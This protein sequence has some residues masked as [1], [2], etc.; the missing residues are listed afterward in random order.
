MAQQKF[1]KSSSRTKNN[2][3]LGLAIAA[4]FFSSLVCAA[5]PTPATTVSTPHVD[6]TQA[7]LP[8]T[9]FNPSPTLSPT[10]SCEFQFSDGLLSIN[11]NS[12]VL[13]IQAGALIYVQD[14]ASG[15]ILVNTD[16]YKNRPSGTEDFIGFL[17]KNAN[18]DLF[19]RAPLQSSPVSFSQ[20]DSCRAQLL[21]SAVG[22]GKELTKSQFAIDL[23]IEPVSG[24]LVVQSTGTE[25]DPI[26]RPYSINIPIMNTTTSAVILGSGAMYSRQDLSADDQTTHVDYGLSAPTMAVIQ[27]NNSVLAA[28]SETTRFAPEYI[29]LSHRPA[30][31][32]L[33]LH[34]EQDAAANDV[35]QIISPPWRINTY[36]AW[37]K[38]AKDWRNKFEARTGAKPLWENRSFWVRN[39]H[40]E[41]DALF[42]DY[43]A[44]TQKYA[45]LAKITSP[46]K[47]LFFLWNGDRIVLYGDPTL[48]G[49]IT[50]PSPEFLQVIKPYGWPLILYHSYTIID[51]RGRIK[52]RL[53]FLTQ[54]GWLPANYQFKPIYA[55]TPSEWHDYWDAISTNYEDGAKY[56]ILHPGSAKFKK[57]FLNNLNDYLTRYQANGAYLDIQG[58]DQDRN[59]PLERRVIDGE[60]YVLGEID[61]AK[62]MAEQMP[63]YG[64]MSEYQSPW[65]LPYIFFSWEGAETHV[66][67]N[68]LAHTRLNHPLH[69]A[70]TGSYAW[71][72]ESS[73]VHVDDIASALLGTLPQISLEGDADISIEQALWSQA[74][75]RLFCE[76]ELFNDLP[77][78]WDSDTLAYYRSIK[79]GNWFKFKRIEKTFGYVEIMPDGAEITRLVR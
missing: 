56:L 50:R 40:A 4:L 37:E 31:D 43:G 41:F 11:T 24:S 51:S 54:K 13:R 49:V 42:Q 45:E 25:V 22:D 7:I 48:V 8:P 60:D 63:H 20:I 66:R 62:L 17:V 2:L 76:E 53:D 14:K 52:K 61:V 47:T 12:M 23:T 73:E 1:N 10:R 9:K 64:M 69:V 75:A 15:E 68:V 19:S 21:Y 67:Q 36:S 3:Y 78:K 39:V 27:G 26:L 70:L 46:G 58:A 74:R 59:F 79:T 55:G 28:W 77:E 5:P 35:Q 30:Y 72:R 65:I 32:Q 34:A 18:G 44:D 16:P 57:Y 29:R 33:I 6:A 71:M 38:A